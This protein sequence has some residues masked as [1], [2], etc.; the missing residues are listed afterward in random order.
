MV[1]GHLNFDTK[2]NEKGFNK[3]IGSIGK[4]LGSI[5]S[6][7][8]GIGALLGTVFSVQMIRNFSKEAKKAWET[9]LEA[10]ARLGQVMRNTMNATD[11]QIQSVKEYSSALQELGVI[12]DEVQLSGLQELGTYVRQ[13][14]SLKK[15]NVVLNDMLAQQYGLNATA[16]NAVT[17]ATMLGKV[18]DGQTSALSRYGYSFDEAQEQLLKYG[19]EE[20]RVATLAEVVEQSVGGMN[21]ALANTDA[22]RMKQLENTMGDI[23][24]Q[25]GAAVTQIQVIFLPAL[26]RVAQLL[27][28]AAQYARSMAQAL[29]EVFGKQAANTAAAASSAADSYNDMADAAEAA[30]KANDKSLASFDQINKLSDNDSSSGADSAENLLGDTSLTLGVDVDTSPAVSKLKQFFEDLR[31]KFSEIFSP[32]KEAWENKGADVLESMKDSFVSVNDLA[33][34]IGSS[35]FEVWTNG[36]GTEL[37]ESILGIYTNLNTTVGNLADRLKDAWTK[38]GLGTEIVQN[39]ADIWGIWLGHIE[40][41]TGKI[42]AWADTV[43]FTP[44]LTSINSLEEALQPIID[45][46]GEGLEWLFDNVLLPLASWTLE[47]AVPAAIDTFSA[48][49]RVL[50]SVAKLLKEPAQWLWNNFLKPLGEWAGDIATD[51]LKLLASAL[52]NLSGWIDALPDTWNEFQDNFQVGMDAIT[53]AFKDGWKNIKETFS[54]IGGWFSDRWKDI[55]SAFKDTGSWFKKTFSDAKDNISS[56]FSTIGSWAKDRWEDIKNAFSNVWGWFGQ[57]FGSAYAALTSVFSGIKTYFVNRKND[58]IN[59]FKNIGNDIKEKFS[60]AWTKIKSVFSVSNMKAHFQSIVN[61]IQSLFSAM[62]DAIKAPFNAAIDSINSGIDSLNGLSIDVDIPGLG[63]RK[64]GFDIPRIPKLAQGMAVPANYGE[65]LAILGDNKRE[66]EVV[67]P[68]SEIEAAVQRGMSKLGGMG[69]GDIHITCEID[70]EKVYKTVVKRNK[71]HVDATGKNE[72]IY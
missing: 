30:Q 20:Q 54:E 16:E 64:I 18:L 63:N 39:A 14:E 24:E 58:V 53:G 38:D 21:A 56:A 62:A 11:E 17:I 6:K 26:K 9:Q 46:A 7:L 45:L 5:K 2:I 44:L 61:T 59:A 10:E 50:T 37:L 41:I 67:T 70:G 48:K 34:E 60:D 65:F 22:G 57:T 13:A 12:G 36:T 68:V 19:T 1:D 42:A 69:G 71:Q 29:S 8:L 49:L 51:G 72:F 43:D 47:E 23:K 25:F 66:T 55:K 52:E 3:G 40:N 28:T 4:G 32:F 15:M 31:A 35:I 33:K 27:A